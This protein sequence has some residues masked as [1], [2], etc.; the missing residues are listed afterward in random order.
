MPIFKE[1]RTR[2]KKE[3]VWELCCDI[4]QPMSNGLFGVGTWTKKKTRYHCSLQQCL[5]NI[6]NGHVNLSVIHIKKDKDS[7]YRWLNMNA[8]LL[9]FPGCVLQA[10]WCPDIVCTTSPSNRLFM[11]FFCLSSSKCTGALQGPLE[12]LGNGILHGKN[13]PIPRRKILL[14]FSVATVL[15][16]NFTS[17]G[18]QLFFLWH[19]KLRKMVTE[20]GLHRDWVWRALGF[21]EFWKAKQ[22]S[23]FY[24]HFLKF[25]QQA[26]VA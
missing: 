1:S 6:F 5:R 16:L 14:S 15:L 10:F 26:V 11:C 7:L 8:T 12:D 17:K 18:T 2:F 4:K 13:I 3:E 9:R 19:P 20:T 24:P 22:I 23:G 25:S 21:Q